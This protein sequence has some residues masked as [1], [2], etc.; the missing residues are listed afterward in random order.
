ML[1]SN[2]GLEAEFLLI[3]SK[4]NVVIPPSSWDRDG[5]PL[6][7]EV[8]GNCGNNTPDV[9][10][11]F[12]KKLMEITAKVKKGSKIVMEDF[13]RI[14]LAVYKAAMKQVT[15]PK[16]DQVGKVKNVYEINI[17]DY[18]DQVLE[19]GKIQGIN[20]S[21]GLHI[22]FSC[23]ETVSKIIEDVKYT[24]VTLPIKLAEVSGENTIL[25]E[26]IRPEIHLYSKECLPDKIK[27]RVSVFASV[28][29]KPVVEYIVKELDNAFFERFAPKEEDRTKYR[30][31]G[32]YKLKPYGFEY[33][34]LP[35]NNATMEALPEI[36][37]KALGLLASLNTWK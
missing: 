27:K 37:D 10:A 6:L 7:G 26:L 34:S 22:H 13:I 33:R 36:V 8:R 25:T 20:S 31:P 29:T 9:V 11:N 4:D 2:V 5:F 15:E 19:N 1:E 14:R 28:L 32:F 18:S 35:A 21:C 12:N 17:E 16:S 3:D 30:R 24:L 23:R